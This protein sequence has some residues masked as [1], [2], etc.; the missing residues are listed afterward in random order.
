MW[1]TAAAAVLSAAVSLLLRK[2]NPETAL[3][4]GALTA[5]CLVFSSLGLLGGFGEFRALAG[6]LMGGENETLI[7]PVLKCLAIAVVTKLTGE[8][9]RD[10]SQRSAAAAV[11][12]A[13]AACSIAVVLPLLMS[14]LKK[15]GGLP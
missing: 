10:A 14:V 1:K 4:L 2:H 11:D 13:G 8:I 15:I 5:V 9:C 6:K 12:L 7:A 3:L